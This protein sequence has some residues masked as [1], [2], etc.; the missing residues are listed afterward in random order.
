MIRI[1]A[2]SAWTIDFH[3]FRNEVL[4][5]L[6]D[7]LHTYRSGSDLQKELSFSSHFL[8]YKDISE[9]KKINHTIYLNNKSYKDVM[10]P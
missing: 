10:S 1:D 4:W 3:L 6:F 9:A 8:S 5:S 2:R 7:G